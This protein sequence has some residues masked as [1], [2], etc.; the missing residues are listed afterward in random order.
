MTNDG[1][2]SC[3]IFESLA[4]R[5]RALGLAL[6][7]A[8]EGAGVVHGPVGPE[9][10][11]PWLE[12]P[13][14]KDWITEFVNVSLSKTEPKP[15]HL[16]AGCRVTPVEIQAGN[17]TR[18]ILIA[19]Q[20]TRQGLEAPPFE[21][22]CRSADLDIQ[23]TR[24]QF[25]SMI[26]D[27]PIS[28]D[29]LASVIRCYFADLMQT[30]NDHITLDEFG[31]KL[32]QSYEETNLLYRLARVMNVTSDPKQSI[33]IACG[34]I[35]AIMPFSWV[36]VVFRNEHTVACLAGQTIAIGPL[37]CAKEELAGLIQATL[38]TW[39]TD[40]WTHIL[41]EEKHELARA[42]KS[43]LIAE[44]I[45]HDGDVIGALL[46]G[47]KTGPDPDISSVETQFFD[48]AADFIGVFH[49]NM[50]RFEEQ[51][52][53]FLGTVKGLTA[54]IDAKDRYT[55]GHSERVAHLAMQLASA[56][57]LTGDEIETIR[58]SGLVHDIGKI[59]IPEVVLSKPS[60]LTDAEFAQ[61]KRHPMIGYEIL[62]DIPPLAGV[63]PG[64]RYH[65]ERW[66][67]RGYPDGLAGENIPLIGRI[68]ACADAF[69][70]MSSTRS[71][72][73]ALAREKVLSEF[74]KGAGKQFD[75]SLATLFVKLDFSKFDCLLAGQRTLEDSLAA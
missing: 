21:A 54:A 49:E 57:G 42:M 26:A 8:R 58:I 39:S 29:H 59:G 25:T 40:S 10:T 61:I 15:D 41:N 30:A 46:A 50:A 63:L 13:R 51:R 64:V 34:Q 16:F 2:Q 14:V 44:P 69:D 20:I 60:G 62:K 38:N 74:E 68:L 17:G 11:Q 36:A 23:A 45:T 53:M 70:A 28:C 22:A 67:G 48:A 4:E 33:E 18:G 1:E 5:C 73:C 12:S 52:A 31:E 6:W 55:C 72:R 9:G 3:A 27:E 37:P 47:G 75:P 71:Y 32:T 66:D 35:S 65:H 7:Y 19:M 24:E 56:V 43:E